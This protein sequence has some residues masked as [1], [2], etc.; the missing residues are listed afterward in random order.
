MTHPYEVHIFLVIIIFV[1]VSTSSVTQANFT[2]PNV[3]ENRDFF[4]VLKETE[5]G[6][7]TSVL[8]FNP[9]PDM[10]TLKRWNKN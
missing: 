5:I 4:P 10:K 6:V 7:H 2:Q 3:F 1:S 8:Y 9:F